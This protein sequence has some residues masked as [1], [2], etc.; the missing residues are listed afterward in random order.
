MLFIVIFVLQTESET[1]AN[2]IQPLVL[3]RSDGRVS[4]RPTSQT[5]FRI[6]RVYNQ[7]ITACGSDRWV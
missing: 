5:V 1:R 7:P 3:C 4:R 6:R 2:I